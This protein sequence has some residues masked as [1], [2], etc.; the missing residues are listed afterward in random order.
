MSRNYWEAIYI[1][2]N[3]VKDF[4]NIPVSDGYLCYV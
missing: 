3:D 4:Q 2:F 1:K